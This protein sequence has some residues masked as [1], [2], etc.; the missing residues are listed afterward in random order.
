MERTKFQHSDFK[1]EY[2][3]DFTLSP[4]E[5][6]NSVLWLSD[7][8]IKN[9]DAKTPWQ[10]RRAQ[11]AYLHYYDLLNSV[12]IYS[13]MKEI[14][15]QPKSIS[16]F[17]AGLA[18]G[19]TAAKKIW[20][21][22][23]TFS[24]ESSTVAQKICFKHKGNRITQFV[25]L[26]E[27]SRESVLLASYSM[28]ELKTFPSWLYEFSHLLIVEP[29]TKE[30]S[31]RLQE[32]RSNAIDQGFRVLAPC[33]HQKACPL[34][35]NSKKDWCHMKLTWDMPNWFKEIESYL[36]IKNQ[37]IAFSYLLLSRSEE[38]HHQNKWRFIGDPLKQKGKQ[39]QMLCFDENRRFLTFLSKR[40]EPTQ[41]R[42]GDL[43]DPI[44]VVERG[45][46]L[47]IRK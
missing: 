43:I 21:E 33:T 41:Y 10:D 3:F 12:R 6:A 36:P 16:D 27:L 5:I 44:V 35:L 40:Q 29:S 25:E 39:K 23:Q 28:T 37:E 32:F 4:K 1:V 11:T 2:H 20:P 17:G 18:A 34:L 22:I 19:S 7:Y 31:R 8:Y 24:V 9:P 46:E 14:R 30:D 26:S 42:R 13:A 15:F 45:D 47:R 38:N